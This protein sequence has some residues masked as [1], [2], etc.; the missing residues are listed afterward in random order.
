M[1][2]VLFWQKSGLFH[3]HYAFGIIEEYTY[4]LSPLCISNYAIRRG[5]HAGIKFKSFS[6][7]EKK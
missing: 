3:S 2:Y 5:C 6:F 4:I 7:K 1:Q